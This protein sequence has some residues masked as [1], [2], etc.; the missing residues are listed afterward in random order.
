MK[1]ASTIEAG[2]LASRSNLIRHLC[3]LFH[4]RDLIYELVI[5]DLKARYKNSILGFIW[6]LLNPLGMMVV[7]TIVFTI[8]M[9]NNSLPK[10]PIFLLSGILPWNFFNAGVMVGIGSIVGSAG[11]VK[12]VYFPRSFAGSQCAG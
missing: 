4:S 2:G 3:E 11:L 12:K 6:S 10:Y 7:F 1:A 9:P 5:R 8:M